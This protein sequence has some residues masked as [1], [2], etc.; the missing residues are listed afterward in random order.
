VRPEPDAPGYLAAKAVCARCP[1]TFSCAV[2]AF[3][4]ER[5]GPMC[6]GV[7]AGLAPVERRRAMRA[8]TSPIERAE[9]ALS[10]DLALAYALPASSDARWCVSAT[11]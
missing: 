4:T 3:A 6:C 9:I 5:P 10:L 7:R 11:R 2:D 8:G 1:V